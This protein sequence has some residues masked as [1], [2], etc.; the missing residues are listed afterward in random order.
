VSWEVCN[1]YPQIGGMSTE[2]DDSRALLSY[3]DQH[4]IYTVR[5]LDLGIQ[6]SKRNRKATL[7]MTAIVGSIL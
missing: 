4:M 7:R 3:M 2:T 5:M 6:N 1:G